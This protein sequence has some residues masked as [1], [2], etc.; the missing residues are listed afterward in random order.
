MQHHEQ[1]G[2]ALHHVPGLVEEGLG[3]HH[4]AL[5]AHGDQVP[6]PQLLLHLRH[7]NAEQIGDGG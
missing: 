6:F 2:Q 3:H 7:W 1:P 5:A 4:R